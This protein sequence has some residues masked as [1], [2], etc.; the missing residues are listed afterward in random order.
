MK[1]TQEKFIDLLQLVSLESIQ[2]MRL[3]SERLGDIPNTGSEIQLNYEQA[4][5]EGD[6]LQ[7]SPGSLVFRMRCFMKVLCSENVIFQQES[8]F[9]VV[10]K[11]NDSIN[12]NNLWS[13][14]DINKIFMEQQLQKTIWP[15]FREQVHSGMTRLGIPPVVL[16]WLL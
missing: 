5:A 2:P 9:I 1:T 6:P 7:E 4:F 11:T 13:D 10:F 14:E 3:V 12:F 15:F 8:T 16:P